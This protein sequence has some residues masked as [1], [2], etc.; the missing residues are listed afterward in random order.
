ML[1]VSQNRGRSDHDGQIF[2]PCPAFVAIDPGK[3]VG[4]CRR[5]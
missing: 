4:R 5:R 1:E 2:L 3:P